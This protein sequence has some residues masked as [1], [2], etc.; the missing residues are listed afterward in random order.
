MITFTEEQQA[1]VDYI[2]EQIRL[3][4][5]G[6]NIIISGQGGVGKTEMICEVI[7]MLL[8]ENKSV[9]VSA[10]TGKATAVLRQK[11]NKKL[12][13]KGMIFYDEKNEIQFTFNKNSL[14]IETIQK[15]TKE[16]KI[17]DVNES[18]ETVYSNSWKNPLDFNYDVLIIDELSMIPQYVSFWWQKTRARVIGLGDFCQLPEVMTRETQKELAGFRHDLKIDTPHMMSGYGIKVLKNLSECHLTKVLR[19]DN[20]IALLS[21]DLRDFTMSKDQLVRCMKGWAEKAPEA[22]SYSD[23]FADLETDDDWQ[24]IS[25][26]NKM[27]EKINDLLCKGG[28]YPIE[29]DKILLYDNIPPLQ[30]FNGDTIRLG[31]LLDDIKKY[32]SQVKNAARPITVILKWKNN[33]PSLKSRYQLDREMADSYIHFKKAIKAIQKIRMASLP[34]ILDS[35]GYAQAQLEEWKKE[36]EDLRKET[37]DDGECFAKIIQRFYDIDRNMAQFIMD[38]APKLPR[39]YMVHIDYGYCVTTHKAQGS[40]YPKVCYILEKFDKPLV[41]TGISRAKEKVKIINLTKR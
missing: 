22:I 33:M 19:S 40:E 37:P 25:Y 7:C 6:K 39:M 15:I 26:T 2:F 11:V 16:S 38:K 36:I 35:S 9:A 28:E 17:V 10:M 3:G 31:D 12:F 30:H 8:Q 14:L 27:C 24:I 23:S 21:N 13:E 32:N 20:E 34:G 41:Y 5:E 18:G 1:I 29:D 4:S